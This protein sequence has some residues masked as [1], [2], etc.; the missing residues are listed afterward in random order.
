MI[1]NKEANEMAASLEAMIKKGALE[2]IKALTALCTDGEAKAADRIAAAKTLIE[3]SVR[4][5]P[6]A[7][8]NELKVIFDGM[9]KE[10]LN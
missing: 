3:Y 1:I 7:S 8:S 5:E 10:Y 4:R 6:D 9:K 2:G